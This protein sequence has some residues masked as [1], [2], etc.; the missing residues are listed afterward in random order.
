M[1][2]F[3][4]DTS[5]L[6]YEDRIAQTTVCNQHLSS[7]VCKEKYELYSKTCARNEKF[8]AGSKMFFFIIITS[9]MVFNFILLGT[10]SVTVLCDEFEKPKWIALIC[11]CLSTLIFV[12]ALS[13]I[14]YFYAKGLQKPF[15]EKVA[16]VFIAISLLC[17]TLAWAVYIDLIV[18][19]KECKDNQENNFLIPKILTLVSACVSLLLM[20]LFFYTS[21]TR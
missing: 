10:L 19:L 16:F 18:S 6:S 15:S 13:V 5:C 4:Y 9:A 14:I 3:E 21:L 17:T 2:S 11:A 20:F 7:D 12:I 8:S 1:T